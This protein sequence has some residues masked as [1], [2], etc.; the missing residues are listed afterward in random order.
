MTPMRTAS[1]GFKSMRRAITNFGNDFGHEARDV[2]NHYNTQSFRTQVSKPVKC[3]RGRMGNIFNS[4]SRQDQDIID[5]LKWTLL[6]V[7]IVVF[8]YNFLKMLQPSNSSLY[9]FIE[10]FVLIVCG[11]LIFSWFQQFWYGVNLF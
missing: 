5:S 2:W 6:I 3:R 1:T 8:I 10:F 11:F 7:F 9:R 4:V